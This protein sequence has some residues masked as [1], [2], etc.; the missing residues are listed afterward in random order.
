MCFNDDVTKFCW[1]CIWWFLKVA[2]LY[3]WLCCSFIFIV[4]IHCVSRRSTTTS[5]PG[6]SHW[7]VWKSLKCNEVS[8]VHDST[9]LWSCVRWSS[10][11]VTSSSSGR[12]SSQSV[13]A[14]SGLSSDPCSCAA[15]VSPD[16]EI[17]DQ[18]LDWKSFRSF[19][20]NWPFR[21]Y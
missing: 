7:L 21:W 9:L 17:F 11:A 12:S 8:A 20:L 2:L 1:Y 13:R 4:Y 10:S 15:V 18:V 16:S 19:V 3:F 5:A 14:A 6:L